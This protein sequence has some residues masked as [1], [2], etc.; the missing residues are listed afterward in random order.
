MR[1]TLKLTALIATL[2]LAAASPVL[3]HGDEDHTGPFRAVVNTTLPEKAVSVSV[4]NGSV[5]LTV[6]PGHTVSVLG[7]DE[8]ESLRIDE[9]GVIWTQPSSMMAQMADPAATSDST[10][11]A[12]PDADE[13]TMTTGTSAS[14]S[15]DHMEEDATA[16]M[17]SPTT[18]TESPESNWKKIGD[19]GI[20]F[21]HEHRCHFMGTQ[22]SQSLATGGRVASFNLPFLVD[23]EKFS[24]TGDLIFDPSMDPKKAAELLG[25][26]HN[27]TSGPP[28][29]LLA[30]L[31][32]IALGLG[33]LLFRKAAATRTQESLSRSQHRRR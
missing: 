8:E 16:D 6:R 2:S 10:A 5:T 24:L 19:G 33:L 22:I 31:V 7:Y 11:S 23:G 26:T 30:A 25:G 28:P 9:S 12:T 15:M 1:H 17:A 20:V 32:V 4:E 18:Y 13:T 3:A 27:H 14:H 29:L 21:Y